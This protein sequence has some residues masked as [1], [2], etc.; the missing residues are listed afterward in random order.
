MWYLIRFIFFTLLLSGGVFISMAVRYLEV[1]FPTSWLWFMSTFVIGAGLGLLVKNCGRGGLFVA[2][3]ISV[4]AANTLVGTLWPAEVNQNVFR[5]FNTVAKRDQVYHQLKRHFLPVR[6]QDLEVA[7]RLQ[8]GV[9]ED[10]REL[11]V[12]G[13]LAI[14]V[15]AAGLVEAQGL[16]ISQAGDVYVSLS[17]VGKVV[18]LRDHDGDGVSD[19]TTV[20]S[21]GLDRP[22]GLAVDGNI[23]YVA[24]AHQ[25]MRVSPLD[26]ESQ[27]TEVFCRDLPVDSQ[28]WRHTLAVS[29]SS[30]VYVS[31]A[32]GQMED[33]RRDWRYA[34]VVRLD[35]DGRSHPFA[36]GLHE[37]LGLAF[38]PQSGSLWA[39]DDSP[40][41]IGF[42]VH[43]DELNVLRDG[44]DFGWPFCYADRKPDAQLGSLGICQATEPSVM[45]LPSH[46]TPAGI[47]FGD[48]LK[49]DPL[50]RSMLYVAMNGSEHGKQNQGFRLM[51]IPLTDVGR[52]RG[53]GIDLV[54]GWSVDGDVWGRPRDVAVGPDG[55]LYVSDSLAGAVYR[56]CFP[57]HAPHEPADS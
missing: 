40:E 33:P 3:P 2:I 43:P 41:T 4:L 36:S 23:L 20:I 49:A 44:G 1:P 48:R 7:E 52:I 5:A 11:V 39:T 56:I 6:Q 57:F 25:V 45:A 21:R 53:W 31:V 47:V 28:S 14:S 9:F 26:G 51:A 32:A 27:N 12:A 10:D 22:S 15:Y 16:A 13:P 8:R 19:E 50:Y 35:S 46:S 54:S 37:C 17:R 34:S 24:T 55:A 42:E 29:P 38:H 18:R 30:D